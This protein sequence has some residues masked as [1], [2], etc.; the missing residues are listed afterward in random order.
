MPLWMRDLEKEAEGIQKGIKTGHR[1]YILKLLSKLKDVGK[2]AELFDL[3]TEEVQ[4]IANEYG[5]E[6]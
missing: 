4:N 6:F 1:D 2:T 5:Y 3:P